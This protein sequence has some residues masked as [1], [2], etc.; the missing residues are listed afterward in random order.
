MPLLCDALPRITLLR[1]LSLIG[2]R[3]SVEHVTSLIAAA[4]GL[5]ELHVDLRHNPAYPSAVPHLP[6]GWLLDL[7]PAAWQHGAVKAAEASAKI[8]GDPRSINLLQLFP[9]ESRLIAAG[10]A[11]STRNATVYR[12]DASTVGVLEGH[13]ADVVA[14]ATDGVHIVTGD[15]SG[16]LRLWDADTLATAGQLQHSGSSVYCVAV[17]GDLV[18]SGSTDS[19]VK[20][21]R[22]RAR[23]TLHV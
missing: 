12:P 11:A 5:R 6:T 23:S 10:S 20:L 7:G 16:S 9:D 21:W 2:N 3:L 4:A 17:R 13:E 19:T 8:G 18:V 15:T 14:V 22:L 1:H